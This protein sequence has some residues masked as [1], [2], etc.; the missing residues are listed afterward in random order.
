MA[1]LPQFQKDIRWLFVWAKG[2]GLPPPTGDRAT[3]F[4]ERMAIMIFEAGMPEREAREAAAES[5]FGR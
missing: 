5:T 1:E 4:A 2:Q 3:A